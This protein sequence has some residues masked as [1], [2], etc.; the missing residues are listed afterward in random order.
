MVGT[1][2][3]EHIS[4]RPHQTQTEDAVTFHL[5]HQAMTTGLMT[6]SEHMLHPSVEDLT[7]FSVGQLSFTEAAELERHIEECQRC[8]ETLLGLSTEDTFVALL[9]DT[10]E[11]L[12]TRDAAEHA[13][14]ATVES[15]L[16]AHSRYEIIGL[17]AKGGMGEVFKAKHRMMDR[18]VALKV[19]N[20]DLMRNSEAVERFQREVKAAARLSHPNIVRAYDAEHAEGIHFLVMEHVDGVNLADLVKSGGPLSVEQACDCIRHAA[21]GLQHAHEQG[22]VH[23]DMK[24]HNL[25]LTADGTVKILDFGLASLSTRS[26]SSGLTELAQNSSLTSEG[27]IMGT[28]DFISPEQAADAHQADIRSDIYSLGATLYYLLSGKPPFADGNVAEKLRCL[29]E[30][31]PTPIASLRR[32]VPEHLSEVIHRML[33]KD[34]DRRFQT[35]QEVADALAPF[36]DHF[37]TTPAAP[38]SQGASGRY[39]WRPPARWLAIAM[40]ACAF[41]LTGVVYL[42]TDNGTL[43]IECEDE[44]V[45]VTISKVMNSTGE[46][47]L[48]L[49][50][51]DT[52]TG[53]K[54][55]RLASGDYKVTLGE[56]GNEY[57]LNQGGFTLR[58]GD[59]V[60]V[61]V[62]RKAGVEP[63]PVPETLPLQT[64]PI[65]AMAQQALMMQGIQLSSEAAKQLQIKADA[66]P[67]DLE[68]RLQLLAYYSRHSLLTADLREPHLKLATWLVANFPEA[69]TAGQP[70]SQIH[71]SFNPGG[72]IKLKNL[73]LKIVEAHSQ[74]TRILSNAAKFCLQSDRP[75]AE[76]LLKKA[77]EIEPENGEWPERLGQLYQ[78]ELIRTSGNIERQ[79]L[80]FQALEQFELAMSL[81]QSP[82][83]KSS[84]LANLAKAA[85]AAG[86][87]DKAK[88]YAEQLLNTGDNGNPSSN[89]GD[90]MHNANIILGQ[91]ALRAGEN[92]A[93]KSYLLAA[94]KTSG[95]PVLNS[96][97]PNMRLAKELL[98]IGERDIVLEYF[99]LCGK[100]WKNNN[101]EQWTKTVKGGGIPEFGVNLA[102]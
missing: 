38:I 9:K 97:G 72:Y 60:V 91:L 40:G 43:V 31:E 94:G 53:S 16:A 21:M 62:T 67:A 68:S 25:M 4:L 44:K 84:L 75:V 96:F 71:A 15:A 81:N 46:D 24:P 37:R 78:L 59:D 19:I 29:A 63:V 98:E 73:W 92:E 49:S 41:L 3:T 83:K 34:P 8:C 80:A 88:T 30:A 100:F 7:A 90:A 22:M 58:R 48:Q 54:V 10:R 51:V 82:F 28:P 101:L 76:D 52:V 55:V 45:N 2:Q 74:N 5:E 66:D 79:E 1:S 18:N 87:D 12:D 65:P 26:I 57:E 20:R 27:R 13:P 36:V 61:K 14:D 89:S 23:R 102:R 99:E 85:L 17:I 86:A 32:D 50:V 35:P 47:Y 93:A 95:S 42:I 11:N 6:M 56:Q 33:S 70:Y 39:S 69:E 77:R 64:M